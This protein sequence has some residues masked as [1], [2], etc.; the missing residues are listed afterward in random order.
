METKFKTGDTIEVTSL[1]DIESTPPGQTMT[2]EMVTQ[3]EVVS[4]VDGVLKLCTV[5]NRWFCADIPVDKIVA[6][7]YYLIAPKGDDWEPI[8]EWITERPPVPLNFELTFYPN[9]VSE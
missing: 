7:S 6:D 4:V 2:I 9:G 8:P 1:V 3:G 5:P